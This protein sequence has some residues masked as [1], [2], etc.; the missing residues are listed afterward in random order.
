M[1][2]CEFVRRSLGVELSNNLACKFALASLVVGSVPVE[3]SVRPLPGNLGSSCSYKRI[4]G[5]VFQLCITGITHISER[6]HIFLVYGLHEDKEP[7]KLRTAS[8][9]WLPKIS[10]IY[11]L[12]LSYRKIDRTYE[13]THFQLTESSRTGFNE[14]R[15]NVQYNLRISL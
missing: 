10:A 7:C 11:I 9:W 5:K 8:S 3:A 2:Y 1:H 14:E 4:F 6:L 12:E 15:S 13:L